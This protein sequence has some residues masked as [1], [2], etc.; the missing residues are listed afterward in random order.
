MKINDLNTHVDEEKLELLWYYL[1]GNTIAEK[2]ILLYL[3]NS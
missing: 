1:R 2:K 3:I